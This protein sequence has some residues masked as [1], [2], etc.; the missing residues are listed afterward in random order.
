MKDCVCLL[1]QDLVK[2]VCM[3]NWACKCKCG[4]LLNVE[5]IAHLQV[6]HKIAN[7]LLKKGP[8]DD[9]KK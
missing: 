9:Y 6:D 4:S 1:L 5:T 7:P 3:G 8:S 2:A